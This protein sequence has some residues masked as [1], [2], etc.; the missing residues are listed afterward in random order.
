MVEMKI[1][2]QTLE[3]FKGVK[4][5]TVTFDGKNARITGEN[6]SGKTTYADGHN[7]LWNDTDYEGNSRP[8]VRTEGADDGQITTVREVVEVNGREFAFEKS[9]KVKTSKPDAE[10]KIKTTKTNTFTINE[11]PKS[12]RDAADWLKNEVGIDDKTFRMLSHPDALLQMAAD[13]K[14]RSQVRDIL[15]GMAD[16]VTDA[17]IASKHEELAEVAGMLQKY[18][19]EEITAQQNA[20]KRKIR[21]NYGTNGERVDDRIGGL[22]AAKQTVDEAAVKQERADNDA[23]IKKA[24]ETLEGINKELEQIAEKRQSCQWSISEGRK[25]AA[26]QARERKSDALAEYNRVSGELNKLD[27]DIRAENIVLTGA[28]NDKER[29]ETHLRIANDWIA[30]ERAKKFSNVC[31]TCGQIIPEEKIAEKRALFEQER[32]GEISRHKAEAET[33][34][35]DIK[36][37]EKRIKDAEKK[38]TELQIKR[39]D[40]VGVLGD[41]KSAYETAEQSVRT[42][43]NEFDDTEL[44]S[45]IA[46]LDA[47]ATELREKYARFKSARSELV[48][49]SREISGKY[50]VIENNR[51]IDAKVEELKNQRV[52][53]EQAKADCEKILDQLAT[54]DMLKNQHMQDSIN[55]HFHIVKWKLFDRQANGELRT[56]LC[57]PMVDG[58]DLSAMNTG[59]K[60]LAK[61]DIIDGLQRHYGCFYPVWLDNA[62]ALTSNTTERIDM[63]SQLIMLCAVENEPLKVTTVG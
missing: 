1:K 35:K 60:I 42:A 12:A 25:K 53:W 63:Q 4:E 58:H 13:K 59:R 48:E 3:N 5:S 38:I 51:Q 30:N 16:N 32:K 26:E 18:T 57:E 43:E 62:E 17:E 21:E 28:K 36:D 47:K 34:K 29:Y 15:F 39:R 23:A 41:K 20:T 9:Q 46:S 61:L 7:F 2:S 49:Q 14:G 24:D 45:E 8:D 10:G 11:V 27:S 33:A 22:L 6:G 54:L 50:A 37:A 31:P 40:L 55:A 56:D 19:V 44:T 52:N